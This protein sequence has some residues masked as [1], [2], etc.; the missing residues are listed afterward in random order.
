MSENT[1]GQVNGASFENQVRSIT[2][3]IAEIRP[4][5]TEISLFSSHCWPVKMRLAN[6]FNTLSLD[7]LFSIPSPH[8]RPC[9]LDRI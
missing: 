5:V 8:N 4:F 2:S 1:V 6:I 3:E 7:H 9:E